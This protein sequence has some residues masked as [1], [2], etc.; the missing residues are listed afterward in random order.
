MQKLPEVLK[1]NQSSIKNAI[2]D[3]LEKVLV[4]QKRQNKMLLKAILAIP[5]LAESLHG[6]V[7]RSTHQPFRERYFREFKCSDSQELSIA[8]QDSLIDIA[9][10]SMGIDKAKLKAGIIPHFVTKPS[11]TDG[12]PIQN[13]LEEM[14]SSCKNISQ[15]EESSTFYSGNIPEMDQRVPLAFDTNG[16]ETSASENYSDPLSNASC[17]KQNCENSS[18]YCHSATYS[19][20]ELSTETKTVFTY[21]DLHKVSNKLSTTKQVEDMHEVSSIG[22][23]FQN[24]SGSLALE[25]KNK[26]FPTSDMFEEKNETTQKTISMHKYSPKTKKMCL[27]QNKHKSLAC[28]V[29]GDKRCR[30]EWQVE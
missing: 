6:I 13:P 10:S 9:G 3:T 4:P 11:K 26:Y 28:S 30:C 18:K 20:T 16:A 15:Q 27:E 25:C 29:Q 5:L 2:H 19:D 1:S 8:I 24:I 22:L 14:Q 21:K 23:S 12:L 7:T 17:H